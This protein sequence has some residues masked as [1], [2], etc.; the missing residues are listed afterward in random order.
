M[1]KL[2]NKLL[3]HIIV[4]LK[5]YNWQVLCEYGYDG[6]TESL[7]YWYA[8]GNTIDEPLIKNSTTSGNTA[9]FYA[10]DH[11]TSTAALLDSTG[12]VIERY[13]Y[14]AYGEPNIMDASYNPRSSFN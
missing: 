9:Q 13:E 12:A 7:D 6:Q 11:L 5:R 4:L 1:K 14:N 10:Q 2:Q 8:Y 3:I